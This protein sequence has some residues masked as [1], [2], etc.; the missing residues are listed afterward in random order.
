MPLKVPWNKY[1]EYHMHA[2]S[3]YCWEVGPVEEPGA[4]DEAHHGK[5]FWSIASL[6]VCTHVL[7]E[8]FKTRLNLVKTII[9]CVDSLV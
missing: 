7:Q 4:A 8:A 3:E 5:C 6:F 9:I 2:H 1:R